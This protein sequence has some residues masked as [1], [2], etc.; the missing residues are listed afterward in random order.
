MNNDPFDHPASRPS[1]KAPAEQRAERTWVRE[2]AAEAGNAGSRAD[3][4][5]PFR[6][7]NPA[8]EH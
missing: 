7:I 4:G 6:F 2:H 3:R 8:A 1:A 5:V